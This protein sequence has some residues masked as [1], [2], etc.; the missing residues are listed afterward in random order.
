MARP[1]TTWKG[2]ITFGLVAVPVGMATVISEKDIKFNTFTDGGAPLGRAVTDKNAG[3]FYTGAVQRGVLVGGKVV[4]VTDEE[5]EALAPKAS[6]AIEIESFVELAEVDP[7]YFG[8]HEYAMPLAGGE[9]PYALLAATL[10]AS[11]KAGIG[12]TVRRGKDHTVLVRSRDGAILVTYLHYHDE[13]RPVADLDLSTPELKS[14][15][16]NMALGLVDAM[17]ETFDAESYA[18]GGRERLAAFVAAKAE[19]EAPMLVVAAAPEPPVEDF[20]AAMAASIAA[21]KA[22]APKAKAV[23]AAVA[24]KKVAKKAPAKRVRQSA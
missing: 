13:V 11:G 21:A 15:E 3:T 19:G 9:K 12:R 17:T 7:V 22:K 6:A 5:V 8:R 20:M 24:P 1:R 10:E 16:L 14:A 4:I 18:D 23:K 2:T